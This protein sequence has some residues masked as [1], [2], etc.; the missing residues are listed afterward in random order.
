MSCVARVIALMP[1]IIAGL[2]RFRQ[3]RRRGVSAVGYHTLC[4]RADKRPRGYS[5]LYLPAHL[6]PRHPHGSSLTR[7]W[8]EPDSELLVPRGVG[9]GFPTSPEERRWSGE[10]IRQLARIPP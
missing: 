4:E 7:R 5:R 3:C 8:S 1:S 6:V 2:L 9:L 10:D